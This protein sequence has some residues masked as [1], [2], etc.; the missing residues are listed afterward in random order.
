M[1]NSEL[2]RKAIVTLD[3]INVPVSLTEQ[4]AIPIYNASSLMKAIFTK[5]QEQEDKDVQ[6]GEPEVVEEIPND[7]KEE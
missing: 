2:L 4:V 6:I 5:M 1:N 7:E 3:T